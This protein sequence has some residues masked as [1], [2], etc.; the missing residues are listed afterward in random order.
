MNRFFRYLII[1]L[2]TIGLFAACKPN[3]KEAPALSDSV[4][5]SAFSLVSDTTTL[6]NLDK[7]FFTIDL[8]NGLIYNAD[9]L[10]VGTPINKLVISLSTDDASAVN[11]TSVDST[12]SY[13]T[14]KTKPINFTQPVNVE[15]ISRSKNYTK[16]YTIKVNVHKTDPDRLFWGGVQ[17]ASLP[18]S[19]KLNQQRTV[20]YNELLH[21]FMERDNQFFMA[22]TSHPSQE[23]QITPLQLSFTPQFSTL[24]TAENQLFVLDENNT[25]YTSVDGIEWTS[26]Q[27]TFSTIIGSLNNTLLAIT[28]EGN[29]YYHDLYPRPQGYTPQPVAADFPISGHSDILTYNSAWLT[30]PQGMIV[31]GRT[32]TGELTG[33][34]WGFDGTRWAKLNTQLPVRENATFFSYVTFYVDNNWVTTE[35]PTW[36]IIGGNNDNIAMR[37]VWISNNY[38]I[39]WESGGLDLT[40]PGYIIARSNASVVICEDPINSTIS[41]WTSIDTPAMPRGY[42]RRHT[43]GAT[44]TSLVPY[45]YMFGGETIDKRQLDQVWRGVINRLRFEPIP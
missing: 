11:I 36:F 14:Y 45:I 4:R 2:A 37:D 42:S 24:C 34:V 6:H 16:N 44:S 30:S 33:A 10:P 12:F 39:T 5:I 18:G 40:L 25:L 38:G 8:E 32:A 19:G 15:V 28:Q 21:C 20:R 41:E 7:V 26:T 43:F 9:S 17:Y 31:G 35:M 3:D 29:N 22:T 1:V 23:W 27:T 13:L